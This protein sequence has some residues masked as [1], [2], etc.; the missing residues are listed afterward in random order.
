MDCTPDVILNRLVCNAYK[1]DLGRL[2]AK[3]HPRLDLIAST[4]KLISVSGGR[5]V[6]R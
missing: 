3:A 5:A 6:G 2:Y 4:C 1:V